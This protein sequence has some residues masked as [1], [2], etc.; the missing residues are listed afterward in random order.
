[1]QQN[2]R[3]FIKQKVYFDCR[4][5]VENFL[6]KKTTLPVFIF[7]SVYGVTFVSAY[8]RVVVQN[9]RGVLKIWR[10]YTQYALSLD[11]TDAWKDFRE[12]FAQVKP[13]F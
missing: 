2:T 10:Y 11:C 5:V 6:K 9:Q 3:K 12:A 1:M 13:L 4:V 7:A 8:L